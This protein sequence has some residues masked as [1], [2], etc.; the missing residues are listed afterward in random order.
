MVA[1]AGTPRD[2]VDQLHRETVRVLALPDIK[3][4]LAQIGFTAAPNSPDEFHSFI[5]SEIARWAKVIREA[6]I[7]RVE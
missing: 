7:K 3:N 6:D 5:T 2:I 4:R 1:P